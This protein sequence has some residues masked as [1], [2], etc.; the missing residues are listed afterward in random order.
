MVEEPP[1]GR[2]RS[3]RNTSWNKMLA[4]CGG[5]LPESGSAAAAAAGV[6]AEPAPPR[7][8]AAAGP[9]AMPV[10]VPASGFGK[11]VAARTAAVAITAGALVVTVPPTTTLL[12]TERSTAAAA[13]IVRMVRW[14]RVDK[15]L[16]VQSLDRE[17]S[18]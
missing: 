12:A 15:W 5:N 10:S 4:H 14:Q 3:Q 1:L 18:Q 9:D 16:F 8:W 13:N 11:V 6:A 7:T 17:S 2:I